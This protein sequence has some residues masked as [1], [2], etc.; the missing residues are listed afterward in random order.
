MRDY[1]D[2][3]PALY[4]FQ[5]DAAILKNNM[6]L[7]KARDWD[8]SH[9]LEID[10]ENGVMERTGHTA[11]SFVEKIRQRKDGTVQVMGRTGSEYTLG[12]YDASKHAVTLSNSLTLDSEIHFDLEELFLGDNSIY[13]VESNID[14]TILIRWDLAG[15]RVGN[16]RIAR[17][18]FPGT[19]IPFTSLHVDGD[20]AW[21]ATS[22]QPSANPRESRVF[23][24]T[25][26]GETLKYRD[27]REA[28]GEYKYVFIDVNDRGELFVADANYVSK[29]DAKGVTVWTDTLF[30]PSLNE[31]P[32]VGV[33]ATKDGGAVFYYS[34]P[35]SARMIKISATGAITWQQQYW[36]SSPY[37]GIEV[38]LYEL[39]DGS[40]VVFSPS[41]YITRYTPDK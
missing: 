29:V 34:Y 28:G 24:V 33:T 6:L 11:P 5:Y 10:W 14:E 2:L 9:L 8:Y 1:I 26:A 41:G 38:K 4:G 12:Q 18:E 22:D 7:V 40:I 39:P 37:G 23:Q 25:D 20:D 13:T 16:K 3:D 32:Y 15:H 19:R 31:I 21:L 17:K 36:E 30:T 27:A 35:N